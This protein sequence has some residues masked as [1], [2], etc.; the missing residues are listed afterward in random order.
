MGGSM[1]TKKKPKMRL[2][3]IVLD[4][5]YVVNLNDQDMVDQAKECI[6]EDIMSA[7]KYNEIHNYIEVI[8]SPESEESDIPEFLLE[9]DE[10][11]EDEEEPRWPNPQKP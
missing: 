2:G 5:A 7:Y 11:D 6:Y 1:K 9:K 4:L 10:E 8:E 3:K